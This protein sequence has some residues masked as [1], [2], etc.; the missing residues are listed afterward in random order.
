MRLAAALLYACAVTALFASAADRTSL[1][2]AF[3]VWAVVV[4]FVG[5]LLRVHAVVNAPEVDR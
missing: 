3:L 4:L 2:W 1:L 5:A